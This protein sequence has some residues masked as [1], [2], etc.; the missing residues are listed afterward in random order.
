MNLSQEGDLTLKLR[1]TGRNPD[2]E[3]KRPVVLNVEVENNIPQMLR[4]LRAARAVE[5][6]LE[7]RLAR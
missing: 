2:L 7:K 1:L 4:S 3:E 5:D 6:V